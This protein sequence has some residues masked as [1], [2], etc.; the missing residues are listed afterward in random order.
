MEELGKTGFPLQVDVV[1]TREA[2]CEK[3][4]SEAYD[5]ILA[6]Y[7]LGSWSGRDAFHL[8]QQAGKDIPFIL[9]TG[10]LGDEATVELMKEGIAD[11]LLKERLVRLPAAVC[12][13]LEEKASREERRLASA[14]TSRLAQAV[15]NVSEL[16]V[17][18]DQQ[19]KITFANRAFL[20]AYLYTEDEILA[21]TFP[22]AILSPR[23]ST[24]LVEQIMVGI[25]E[26][27]G[28]KGECL[29]RRKDGTDFPVYLRLAQ[30]K[31]TEGGLL[32]TLAIAQ[33]IAERKHAEEALRRS[34]ARVQYLVESNLIGIV[35]GDLGGKL[36]DA[37]DAF[38]RLLGYSRTD[39]LSGTMRWDRLSPPEHRDSDQGAFEQLRKTGIA[40][41]REKQF[42]RKDGTRVSVLIGAATFA[43]AEGGVE[44]VSFVLDVSE[45]KH[46]EQQLQQ[47]QK[48][49]AIGSLTGGIAH[50]FNN[51]LAVIIGYSE[52]M[53]ERVGLDDKMRIPAEEIRKAG[54]RAASLTRQLLAF[55]RQQVIEPRVLHLN[56]IVVEVEKMLRRLIGEDIELQTSLDPAT[57][58]VKADPGQIQQILLNLAVNA[59]DAMP[60]GGNLI[61][62]TGNVELGAAYALHHPPCVAGPYVLLTVSDTGVGMNAET[63]ARIFEPFFTTKEIGKGTGLGLST[64]YGAVRQSGGHVWVYSE[65]GRGTAFKI[66]LPRVDRAVLQILPSEPSPDNLCGTETVL[67]VEDDASLRN[68]ARDLLGQAGYTVLVGNSG[69]HGLKVAQRH[70]APIH[71]LL[72]DVVMPGLNGPAL[73]Q[74][75]A[76]IHPETRVLYVSGYT[77]SFAIQTGLVDSGASLLQ[78]P[79]SRVSLLRKV[80]EV[81]D[82][83]RK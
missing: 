10:A 25:L 57:G 18:A 58:P 23:N 43:S 56:P 62:E 32:G 65:P 7:S 82:L 15:E 51:L 6:S 79:F 12:R 76:P 3:L 53:L 17:L 26:S 47:A 81:L 75:I 50:D 5:V 80:R 22:G 64:V 72:S 42:L 52:M 54:N 78:K 19:G 39:L 36:I 40:P 1:D 49:E 31:D 27:D 30:I 16:I 48:M 11:C 24:S 63:K 41:S 20:Q 28:W 70:P 21:K 4:K 14:K 74:K 8:L 35:I 9:M 66:Y 37:N 67:L 77:G 83:P 45:R 33:D 59:R 38:L 13:A 68:L 73:A 71:L 29:H 55:S 34:E 60:K 44:C 2:F 69:V 46:L 61:I